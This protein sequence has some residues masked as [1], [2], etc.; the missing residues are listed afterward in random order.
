MED[1]TN[2]DAPF[3]LQLEH[4]WR[5]DT[6]RFKYVEA[7]EEPELPDFTVP[8]PLDWHSTPKVI[9]PIDFGE[10]D[11]EGCPSSNPIPVPAG[12]GMTEVG[13]IEPVC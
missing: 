9:E 13:M 5:V 2:T 11:P 7:P 8:L 12:D 1:E 6:L 10:V 3:R 4:S